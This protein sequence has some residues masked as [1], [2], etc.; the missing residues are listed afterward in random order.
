M[1]KIIAFFAAA[2]MAVSCA[3]V[4]GGCE[5]AKEIGNKA[6]NS[7]KDYAKS[8]VGVSG[9][10]SA[11]ISQAGEYAQNEL[12]LNGDNDVISGTWKQASDG[13]VWSFDGKSACTLKDSSGANSSGTYS[14]DAYA[15]TVTVTM[16]GETVVYNYKL[17]K[18]LSSE[19]LELSS[20]E[21]SYKLN[22]Q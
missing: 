11:L 13:T 22:K 8:E 20:G 10:K 16:D 3:S 4:M 14:V 2:V 9:D 18:T 17:R 15:A 19:S 21:T 6:V 12:G 5:T 1:K 7:A